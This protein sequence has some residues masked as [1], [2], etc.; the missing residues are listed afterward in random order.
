MELPPLLVTFLAVVLAAVINRTLEAIKPWPIIGNFNLIGAL[1]H[2]SIHELSKKHGELM[3]LRF[4]SCSVVVGSSA[5]MARL[6]L[7]THDILFLDRPMTAAGKHTTYNY[8]DITWSPYGPYWRHARR[9]C[10]TQLFSPGRLASF[11][12]IRA[13]EVRSLVRGLFASSGQAVHLSRDHMSTLSMNVITRMVLGKRL[14][15]DTGDN[16][17]AGEGPVSSLA[18]FKWMMDELMLLNGVLNVGD[19]IPWMDRLDLQGYVR[20][21]KRIGERFSAFIDHVVDEHAERRRREGESFVARDMV[22]VL[23]QIA[24]DPTSEV[25]IGRVGVKAFTQDLIVGGTD[26]TS[27]TVEWA[28]SELLKKPSIFTTIT[29]ELDRVV[30]RGRWV[31]E[32]DLTCL[33]YLNAIVKETMR[34]HPIVPLLVPRVAR[35]DA[36]VAGYDIPKGTLV[37]INVWT[38]GRDPALWDKP[39][40]FAPE[41]FVGSKIDVKGQD[42]ELLPFGSGRRMCPGYNLGLKEVQLSL[43]NL[44]HGFTWSLPEGMAKEDLSMDEEFG[45]STTRKYPLEVVVQPRLSSELYAYA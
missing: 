38:I 31:T 40:E 36:A 37:L 20:R 16:G 5:D 10:A 28:I 45:L 30:G 12:P 8:A 22:D 26:S 14:F 33:P 3:H 6:F 44:L 39:E 21:M 18:E 11:E 35:E 29:D 2:R 32:K 7:K 41:R 43:A 24:D 4:G 9:I 1:P 42:F 34:M 27:A 25:Q 13:D 17:A 19:W 23:M 15:D